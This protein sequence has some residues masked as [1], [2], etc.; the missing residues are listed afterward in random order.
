MMMKKKMMIG[1]EIII[2]E[3]RQVLK[4]NMMKITQHENEEETMIL[5]HLI[6]RIL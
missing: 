1:E 2:F 3:E 5:N 4:I 6:I